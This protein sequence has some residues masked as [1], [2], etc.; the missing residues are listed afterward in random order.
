MGTATTIPLRLRLVNVMKESYSCKIVNS[1]HAELNQEKF[2]FEKKYI[3]KE[4]HPPQG[5]ATVLFNNVGKRIHLTKDEARWDANSIV[6]I[7]EFSG[8][9]EE[10]KE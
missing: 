8:S 5:C 1:A 2:A 4:C 3:I 7:M 9:G 10:T 6:S